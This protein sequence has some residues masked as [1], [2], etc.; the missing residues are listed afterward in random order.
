M[1]TKIDFIDTG[2][3]YADGGAMFGAIP[4][5]AWSRKYPSDASNSCVL[6]LR[7]MLVT[8]S[9]RRILV[10]TGAG[11]WHLEAM[12]YY[13]FFGLKDLREE[14]R[15][16]GV[17]PEEITD[18]VLTH[19]HF[20]HCGGCTV[21]TG[22]GRE[23]AFPNATHWVSELQL[24]TVCR[25]HPLEKYSF[26][27]EDIEA[28]ERAGK[29]EALAG[30]HELCP[31]VLLL[32]VEAGHTCGQLVPVVKQEEEILFYAGDVIP[33][34]ANLSPGWISAYDLSPCDS[35]DRKTEF[36]QA[37]VRD[38]IRIAYCHDAYVLSS[39]VVQTDSG[40]FLPDR[41]TIWKTGWQP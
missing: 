38:G 9:E 28:V 33:L 6:A 16:R 8:T 39:K 10:D 1:K 26:F 13:R 41:R 32:H 22:L 2:Y 3:F 27:A 37:I 5:S 30:G 17:E 40:L 14:V 19:L 11:T 31:E 21:Q 20:D 15:M 23:L 25:P 12:S 36:L 24:R 34:M 7:S 35:Y 18:V 4:K 29:C